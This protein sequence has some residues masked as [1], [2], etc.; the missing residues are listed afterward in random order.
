[1][2]P[3]ETGWGRVTL[4]V[5]AELPADLTVEPRGEEGHELMSQDYHSLRFATSGTEQS[6]IYSHKCSGAWS[7][8]NC[9][10]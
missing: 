2:V 7:H 3:R 5:P 6:V 1:M 8:A 10:N 4:K 9:F